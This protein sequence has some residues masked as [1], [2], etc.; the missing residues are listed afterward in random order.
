V[1]GDA[2]L[3][4]VLEDPPGREVDAF[5]TGEHASVEVDRIVHGAETVGGDDGQVV[6]GHEEIAVVLD[7][8]GVKVAKGRHHVGVVDLGDCS[9]G[10]VVT[11]E[12]EHDV[13]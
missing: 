5:V 8:V 2:A 6:G 10:V 7:D 12:A 11:G 9:S 1:P 3:I 13:D 4:A